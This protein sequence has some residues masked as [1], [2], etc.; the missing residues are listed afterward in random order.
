MYSLTLDKPPELKI[1]KQP[2]I[3]FFKRTNKSVLSHITFYLEDDDHKP[4]D[5]NGDTISF[6]CELVKILLHSTK[7]NLDMFRLKNQTEDLLLS[8]TKSCETLVKQTY[9]KPQETFDFK[10][11]KSTENFYFKASITLGLDSSWMDGITSLDVYNSIFNI[12]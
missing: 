4:V 6:T 9:T 7:L 5:F 10:L 8:I 11:T 2:R 1:Y 3:K 12:T